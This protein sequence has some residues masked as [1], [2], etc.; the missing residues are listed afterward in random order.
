METCYNFF[1]MLYLCP[2]CVV[3][4][5]AIACHQHDV[6]STTE[7]QGKITVRFLKFCC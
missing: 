3:T 4:S 6:I 7:G 5:D 1:C 2:K